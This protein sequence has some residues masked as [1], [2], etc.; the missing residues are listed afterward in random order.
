MKIQILLYPGF[1]ELDVI[2]PFEVLKMAQSYGASLDVELVTLSGTENEIVG[3]HG[4]SVKTKIGEKFDQ[5]NSD[6]VLIPGGGWVARS[7]RGA[8][9]ESKKGAI[10]KALEVF[11]SKSE[12]HNII[13]TVCTGAMLLSTS[14]LLRGRN[15]TTHHGAWN[16]LKESG[17][18]LIEERVVD[19]GDLISSGG[20][21]AGIDLALW[22]VEKYFGSSISFKVEDNLE[23]ERRGKV[24]RKNS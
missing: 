9:A 24:W 6:L 3:Q 12:P 8:F 14:S 2:G 18:N 10:A 4:L 7:A 17:A 22:L 5:E 15:A 1:D 20:V 23:Y 11:H 13:A 21:T 16:D 19:D